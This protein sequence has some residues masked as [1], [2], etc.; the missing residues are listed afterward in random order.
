[1][2]IV[3]IMNSLIFIYMLSLI[4]KQAGFY[5]LKVAFR[6]SKPAIIKYTKQIIYDERYN[7]YIPKKVKNTCA[8]IKKYADIYLR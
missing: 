3:L 4:A 1:M 7:R 2:N 5:F 8:K 6:K